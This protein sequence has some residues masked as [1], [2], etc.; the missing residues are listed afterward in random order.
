MTSTYRGYTIDH[1]RNHAQAWKGEQ[2]NRMPDVVTQDLS[3][4]MQVIDAIEDYDA[5]HAVTPELVVEI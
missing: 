3:T 1:D 4:A 5:A 2:R